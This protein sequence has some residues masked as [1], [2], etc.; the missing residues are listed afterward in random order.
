MSI[1]KFDKTKEEIK[2][3]KIV[4]QISDI[5]GAIGVAIYFIISFTT[6]AW[7]ITWI[8]FIIV[9]MIEQIVRLI[10]MLKEDNNDEE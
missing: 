2:Q 9:G 8:I 7:H 5:I 1:P 3:D 10:Y 6:M 4:K